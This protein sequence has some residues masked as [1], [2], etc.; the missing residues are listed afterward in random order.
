MLERFT[1]ETLRDREETSELTPLPLLLLLLALLM[2]VL[3]I[4]PG[5]GEGERD[6]DGRGEYCVEFADVSKP[7]GR[8]YD[9]VGECRAGFVEFKSCR[10]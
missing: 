9:R 5:A 4:K 7:L 2:T 8:E 10:L 1:C 6:I 3:L